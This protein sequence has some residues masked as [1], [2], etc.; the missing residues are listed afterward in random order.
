MAATVPP[1]RDV[2]LRQLTDVLAQAQP[3]GPL[4]I[5]VSLHDGEIELAFKALG[6]GDVVEALA[7]YR[8]PDEW[9]AFAVAAPATAHHLDGRSDARHV[10][11]TVM[12][13]RDGTTANAMLTD[14]GGEPFGSPTGDGRLLDACRRVLGLPTPP[15][16]QSV[17]AWS[18]MHWL[19][20]TVASVLRADLGHSLDWR[21][22]RALDRGRH[23]VDASWA[24]V[25]G[26]VIA[27]RLQVPGMTADRARWM[28]DGMFSRE[29]TTAYPPMPDLLDDLRALLDDGVY[30]RLL[31]VACS[32][33]EARLAVPARR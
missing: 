20:A 8:A 9:H 32:R 13:V 14:D 24:V 27:R 6:H 17:A 30:Q 3:D 15:P 1:S 5:G 10:T 4:A 29:A 16:T 25:R 26:D 12:A 28:D 18:V 23:L 33:L 19:D 21:G 7:G 22:V 2:L 11:L 31:A